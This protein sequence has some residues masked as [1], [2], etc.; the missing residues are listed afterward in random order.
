VRP[1]LLVNDIFRR[2]AL[3]TRMAYTQT[4]HTKLLRAHGR[5]NHVTRTIKSSHY[6]FTLP[7][8][9]CHDDAETWAF[10]INVR[11]LMFYSIHCLKVERIHDFSWFNMAY[12]FLS[13]LIRTTRVLIIYLLARR[14]LLVLQ[15]LYTINLLASQT[16]RSCPRGDFKKRKTYFLLLEPSFKICWTTSHRT[17]LP[18]NMNTKGHL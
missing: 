8:E 4:T 5:K 12:S 3:G 2:V 7:W 18:V 13:K 15:Q 16:F 14:N 17:L 11:L 10:N 1:E 9:W 6:L